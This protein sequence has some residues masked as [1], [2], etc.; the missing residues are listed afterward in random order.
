MGDLAIRG[1][2]GKEIRYTLSQKLIAADEAAVRQLAAFYRVQ[3]GNGQLLFPQPAAVRLEIPRGTHFLAVSS[4]AG[5]IDVADL[6]GS[7]RADAE[8][9]RIQLDRIAGDVEIHS[10]GGAAS[11]GSIGGVVRCYSGGGSIRAVR[12]NG[13]AYLETSGGDIQLGQVFGP[14]T[15]F[16]AAG[17]IRIEQAGGQVFADTLGGPI[18][19]LRALGMVVAN[20]SGGPI[21]IGE[22]PSVQCQSAAGTIRLNNVSG[23]LRAATE[24][25]SIVAEI[26]EGRGLADSFLST[27]S[28]D[29]TVL[30]PS[31]MGV[32]I[33][34]EILGLSPRQ[35]IISDFSGFQ[36]QTSRSGVVAVGRINGGGPRLRLTGAGGRIQ[37][38]KK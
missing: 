17:G 19:V 7:L 16:T 36:V 35:A 13:Q 29:I 22:A 4:A 28:G 15:A 21:D 26:L 31:K 25:G 11:L 8:A 14:V 30:I 9:G 38:R 37:I 33:E 24:R 12:I 20:S 5:T 32:T 10:N 3:S 23:T 6:D 27:R 1:K 34:A 2:R 18:A